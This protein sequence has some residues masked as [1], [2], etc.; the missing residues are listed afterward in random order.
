MLIKF[1]NKHLIPF[2]IVQ[3][4]T[5][6]YND[7]WVTLAC[8]DGRD[9]SGNPCVKIYDYTTPKIGPFQNKGYS[10]FG[11]WLKSAQDESELYKRDSQIN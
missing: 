1:S 5:G 8:L 6:I 9:F 2:A 7:G 4:E 10:D 11:D 3:D